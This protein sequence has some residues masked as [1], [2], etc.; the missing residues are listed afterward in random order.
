[1]GSITGEL[2]N[3][4]RTSRPYDAY[5]VYICLK[6]YL[7]QEKRSL[8][9]TTADRV[10]VQTQSWEKKYAVLKNKVNNQRRERIN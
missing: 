10:V 5:F 8:Y 4:P 6:Y 2:K 9:S 1:M 3:F 7:S